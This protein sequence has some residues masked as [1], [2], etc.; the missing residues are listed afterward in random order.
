MTLEQM[1]TD[2]GLSAMPDAFSE[3]YQKIRDT[4]QDHAVKILSDDF[5]LQTL[6]GSYAL[7]PW[8]EL[9]VEAAGQVRQNQAMSLLVCLLEQWVKEGGDP[10]DPAYQPPQGDGLAYDFLH[11]FAALPSIPNSIAHLR[12]RG[13]PE[14]VIASTLQEYD[15]CV[16]TCITHL[17]R[18]AF[19]RGRLGWISR[20]VRNTLIRIGRFK[21]DLPGNYYYGSRIYRHKDGRLCILAD[22]IDV[23]RSGR[24]LGCVGHTDTEGSFFAKL[25]QTETAVTGHLVRGDRVLPETVT[26][27]LSEWELCLCGDDP[28]PRIHIPGD[29][30]FDPQTISDSFA[31]AREI[32][33][34]CY[35]DYPFKAFFCSSWLMSVD[36]RD[37]LKPTS[38]I[39]GFQDCFLRVPFISSGLGVFSFAFNRAPVIPES[40][41][42]LPED[43]S[44][45]RAIKQHFLNGGYIHEGA[46]IFF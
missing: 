13:V 23:H 4:W 26:L 14:D 8:W 19:D 17:G 20:L 38:N 34:K 6:H 5:I 41:D 7:I 31:R 16:N 3:I 28:V 46:G 25:E 29:G 2:L 18:P 1:Q 11:L 44:L 39:L 12:A 32:F 15:Y 24:L 9:V 36:L 21:Y 37:M 43:T 30:G 10:Y 40:F 42:D 22:N 27:P 35:P 33:A 45:Q